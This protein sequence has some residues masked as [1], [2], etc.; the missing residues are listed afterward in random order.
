MQKID[1]DEL[2]D[3]QQN[4]IEK[5]I[6]GYTPYRRKV[7][8]YKYDDHSFV[9]EYETVIKASEAT[10]VIRTS[11][12]QMI[13]SESSYRNKSHC[14]YIFSKTPITDFSIYQRKTNAKKRD[15]YIYKNGVFIKKV[16]SVPEASVETGID[17]SY[18]QGR[19][20]TNSLTTY[21]G[22]LFSEH[23]LTKKQIENSSPDRYRNMKRKVNKYTIDGVFI[24][25]YESIT[26]AAKDVGANTHSQISESIKNPNKKL[27]HGFRWTE[28][29]VD[30]NVILDPFVYR[31]GWTKETYIKR[32]YI[33]EVV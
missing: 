13:N 14:G 20:D 28:G 25:S 26:E 5:I 2:N 32:G 4:R 12:S 21:D 23:R 24:K 10:G 30:P 1:F 6:E 11:I 16:S 29:D 33:K 9:G 31:K 18:I 27:A 7:Y 8:V 22:Y 19:I 3:S 15:I 17:K